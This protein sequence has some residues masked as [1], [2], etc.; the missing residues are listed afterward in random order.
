M[1]THTKRA[2]T[3]ITCTQTP[4]VTTYMFPLLSSLILEFITEKAHPCFLLFKPDVS[5]SSLPLF[6]F[7]LVSRP[8]LFIVLWS[9][10]FIFFLEHCVC[11]LKLNLHF[12]FFS[13]ASDILTRRRTLSQDCDTLS[14]SIM[15]LHPA[16]NAPGYFFSSLISC[17]LIT[18]LLLVILPAVLLVLHKQLLCST[19]SFSEYEVFSN[20]IS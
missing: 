12:P 20:K 19:N 17:I 2:D 6:S 5:S 10:E 18:G 1:Q 7:S 14:S 4:S 16:E 9:G 11:V 15:S 13:A 8:P 3:L